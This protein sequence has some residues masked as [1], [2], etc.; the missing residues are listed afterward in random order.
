MKC[1]KFIKIFV[2]ISWCLTLS[3]AE[4]SLQWNEEFEGKQLNVSRWF[5]VNNEYSCNGD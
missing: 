3:W 2:I 1:S 4:W 5:I